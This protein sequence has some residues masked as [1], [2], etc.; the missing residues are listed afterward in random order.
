M[1]CEIVCLECKDQ[2]REMFPTDNPFPGE[3][4]NL[5]KGKALKEYICDKC[6]AG[7]DEGELCYAFSV[8]TD[9][10][11]RLNWEWDFIE[12]VED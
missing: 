9:Q 5:K 7:I 11:E 4:I 6:N 12:I 10:Q 2:L 1:K 8:W 3:H